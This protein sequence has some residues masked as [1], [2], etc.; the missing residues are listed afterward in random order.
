MDNSDI[1][2]PDTVSRLIAICDRITE[3]FGWNFADEEKDWQETKSRRI[4]NSEGLRAAVYKAKLEATINHGRGISSL[5]ELIEAPRTHGAGWVNCLGYSEADDFTLEEIEQ[6]RIFSFIIFDLIQLY[7]HWKATEFDVAIQGMNKVAK[8]GKTEFEPSP[9]ILSAVNDLVFDEQFKAYKYKDTGEKIGADDI[10][11]ISPVIGF[12]SD[13]TLWL[14]H[15]S[16]QKEFLDNQD[17]NKI[18]VTM[19]GKMDEVHPIY[20]NWLF[21][22][23]KGGTIWIITDQIDFDNPY[24]KTA[25]LGRKSVWRDREAMHDQCD[26]PY[27]L[28]SDIDALRGNNNPVTR[29]DAYTRVPFE[30]ELDTF[31]ENKHV[32]FEEKFKE[33]LEKENV[34]FDSIYCETENLGTWR[35]KVLGAYARLKGTTVAYMDGEDG[36]EIIVY[37][38]PE[39]FFKQFSILSPGQQ[40][41]TILLIKEMIQFLSAQ[42][43]EPEK[44]MLNT[45]FVSMKLLAGVKIDPVKAPHMEYWTAEHKRIF[46]E[47]LETLEDGQ[48]KTTAVAIH[49]FEGLVKLPTYNASWLSTPEKLNSLAEWS[50]LDRERDL[51]YQRI[52]EL[53]KTEKE[54]LKWLYS[55]LNKQYA[56]SV[57]KMTTAVNVKFRFEK[58]RK[59]GWMESSYGQ[60]GSIFPAKSKKEILGFGIGKIDK[61]PGDCMSCEKANPMGSKHVKRFQIRHYKELMWLFGYEDRKQLHRYFRQYRA[62]NLIP[63]DGNSLLDQTHPYL[64]LVDPCSHNNPNGLNIELYMCGHC[65]RK[66]KQPESAEIVLPGKSC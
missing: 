47:L 42:N 18:F 21:T 17:P 53:A 50:I 37:H 5:Y 27:D 9:A 31:D 25:R 28:F 58:E 4:N 46:K 45:E 52:P 33:K 26:L 44:V 65:Y 23:H 22:M 8:M 16:R 3:F 36:K 51:I 56:N 20:S 64:G 34:N 6:Q 2:Q 66:I 11:Y 1:I 40:T 14:D 62:H 12:S 43:V 10:Y 24:Q 19:F 39:F 49:T 55:E 15:V 63:Y 30:I 48:E 61:H 41:F 57:Q 7:K 35:C 29:N 38:R 32:V 60:Y 59:S 54:A 13:L